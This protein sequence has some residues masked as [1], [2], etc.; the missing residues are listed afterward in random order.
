M[1][2]LPL[3]C[4]MALFGAAVGAQGFV[5]AGFALTT[6]FEET[7]RAPRVRAVGFG[8]DGYLVAIDRRLELHR[9]GAAPRPL[10]RLPAGEDFAFVLATGTGAVFG[11][12]NSGRVRSLDLATATVTATFPGVRNG[13]DAVLLPTGDALVNANPSWPAAGAHSGV[14]LVGPGRVPREIL[15]LSGPSSALVLAANGDLVVGGLGPVVPPPPGVARLLS[16]PA[17]LVQQALAGG[18]VST[19][20][21]SAIGTG[22]AGIYD[23]AFDDLGRLHV[24]DPMSGTVH[25][26]PAGSLQPSGITVDLGPGRYALQLAFAAHP[27]A[28]F[29]GYQP[30]EHAPALLVSHS[31]FWQSFVVSRL[32]P[33]RPVLAVTPTGP[34]PP[35][36]ATLALGGAP[37]NGLAA[38]LMTTAA[39][40]AERI[41]LASR[42]LA[43]SAWR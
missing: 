38:F 35:G 43:V 12:L 23:L 4:L 16:F 25:H 1:L 3:R 2:Q 15:P 5:P 39:P 20:Q 27:T 13:F 21:A 37:A 30:P 28:P 14:W 17:A 33:A 34:V 36:P 42:T 8:A 19:S 11:E 32:A 40:G 24:T 26:C 9:P 29:R 41:V 18:V 10:W 31:D 22:F 6:A 7:V